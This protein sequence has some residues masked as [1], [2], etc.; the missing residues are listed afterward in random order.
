MKIIDEFEK[1]YEKNKAIWWYTRASFIYGVLNKALRTMDF[2]ILLIMGFYIQDLHRQIQ[3]LYSEQF[4]A[5]VAQTASK[6]P[7]NRS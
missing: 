4:D 1:E 5:H 2:T 3:I 6:P 7:V